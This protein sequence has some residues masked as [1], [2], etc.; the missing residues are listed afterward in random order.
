MQTKGTRFMLIKRWIGTGLLAVM[1]LATGCGTT[2]QEEAPAIPEE[3]T[4][5]Q[6]EVEAV[7][8]INQQMVQ[9][10]ID[11]QLKEITML[12]NAD[13]GEGRNSDAL[14]VTLW[15]DNENPAGL[16]LYPDSGKMLLAT[17]E[18]LLSSRAEYQ[19]TYPNG[20]VKKGDLYF[21]LQL[22]KLTE[23]DGLTLILEGPANQY[24][25][26]VGQEYVFEI[27]VKHPSYQDVGRSEIIRRVYD[28]SAS[29][30]GASLV[31]ET[32]HAGQQVEMGPMTIHLMDVMVYENM[33]HPYAAFLNLD[34]PVNFIGVSLAVENHSDEVVYFSNARNKLLL[35]NTITKD[36]DH[37]M[38]RYIG[39]V[40]YGGAIKTGT[41]FF[42][43]EEEELEKLSAISLLLESP[44]ELEGE[45]KRVLSEDQ[46]IDLG[47]LE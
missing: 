18:E 3:A 29:L 9:E 35:G 16:Q 7:F 24:Y 22:T 6:E 37:L 46:Q 28:L 33:Q 17:G 1:L 15:V 23:I 25:E 2:L 40:F 27:P 5:E 39:Q 44:W 42:R 26:P 45:E 12:K 34:D 41:A 13:L 31:S 21:P 36:M 19:E 4:I 30:S 47:G 38:S 20:T 14:V 10:E 32:F 11:V 8:D 43:I